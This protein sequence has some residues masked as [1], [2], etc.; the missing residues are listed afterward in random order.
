MA[1]TAITTLPLTEA[2]SQLF[3]LADALLSGSADQVQLTHRS[4]PDA[5]VLVRASTLAQL[6]REVAELRGRVGPDVRPL[7]G[8]ATLHASEEELD[9]AL[10]SARQQADQA[11]SRKLGALGE[12]LAYQPHSGAL[13]RV[14][15]G[16]DPT[17]SPRSRTKR[18][19]RG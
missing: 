16:P 6:T 19:R 9:A 4:H 2:R 1:P 7:A 11:V 18:S 13:S 14:A 17:P 10:A 8:L 15:E 5:L 12:A 3:K